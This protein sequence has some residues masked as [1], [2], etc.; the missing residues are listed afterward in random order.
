[1]IEVFSWMKGGPAG[2]R[3]WLVCG[4]GPSFERHKEIPDL[5][6]KYA[7]IGLNHACRARRMMVAHMID[8]NVLDE[9]PDLKDQAEWLLMPWQPHI[10]FRSTPKTLQDFLNERAD[11]QGFESR[12]RLLWYNCST[13]KSPRAGSPPVSVALF[14]AEAVV[15]LLAMAG[16]KKI[17]TLGVDGGKQYASSFKDIQPFRGGHTTFDGQQRYI[18]ATVDQFKLDYA[19][20]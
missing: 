15:R 1:M 13:G 14:S 9:L 10:Q 11:L 18:Q 16:V 12:G 7:T 6:G 4:K 3:T 2:D 8:A 17:R 19:P 20:L 5:D